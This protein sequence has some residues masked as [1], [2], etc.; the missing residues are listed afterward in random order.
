MLVF[1]VNGEVQGNDEAVNAML[2]FIKEG[3]K[4]ARVSKLH[5]EDRAVVEGERDFEIRR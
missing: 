1:Q 4:N 3:P 5:L 2:E